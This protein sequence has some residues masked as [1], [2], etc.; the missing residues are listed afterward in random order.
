MDIKVTKLI[1]LKKI[2]VYA[3]FKYH[4]MNCKQALT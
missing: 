3:F 4:D 2:I 1:D